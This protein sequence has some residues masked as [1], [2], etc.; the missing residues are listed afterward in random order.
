M[1]LSSRLFIAS[2][3]ALAACGGETASNDDSVQSA[4]TAADSTALAAAA[5]PALGPGEAMLAVPGGRIWYK[6]S[7]T[8]T[9]T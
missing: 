2:L 3:C 7:G 4:G 9:G 8:G 1:R 5:T 6:V